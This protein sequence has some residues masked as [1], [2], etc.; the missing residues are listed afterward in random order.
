MLMNFVGK[1]IELT[2]SLKDVAEKKFSKLDKYF[3]E[4]V[5]ARVVFSTI[6]E[7]QT[8]EVTIFLP[9]TIIRAEETT[10]DMYSSMDRAVDALARQI[11][12]HKTKLKKRYQNNET[13]RFDE[14]IEKESPKEE[15][16]IVKRKKFELNP[17][18]EEEAILQMELLN[19]KFFVFLDASTEKVEILYKRND[20]NYGIIE[21]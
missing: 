12:K 16:K 13:I 7:E 11:R 6:R 15:P 18:S 20:G 14:I 2:D 5:E 17:M 21:V 3:S 9:K 8:V 1:N 4:E 19:H 10:D